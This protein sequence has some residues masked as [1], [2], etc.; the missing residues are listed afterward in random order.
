MGYYSYKFNKI[1][2][3]QV[4]SEVFVLNSVKAVLFIKSTFIKSTS[5]GVD[6]ITSVTAF[7][8]VVLSMHLCK[9]TEY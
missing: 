1:N 4:N 6:F 9:L 8:H 3:M 7:Q 5:V 2:A